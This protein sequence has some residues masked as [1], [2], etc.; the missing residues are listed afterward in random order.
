[1]NEMKAYLIRSGGR[2]EGHTSCV[3][4]NGQDVVMAFFPPVVGYL[5]KKALQK[6]GRG[7]GHHRTPLATP[8]RLF[9]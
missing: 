5:L 6:G 9:I 3:D 7:Y 4:V 1:M 2:G 8:L